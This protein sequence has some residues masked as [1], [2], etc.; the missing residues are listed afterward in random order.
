MALWPP[1][2]VRSLYARERIIASGNAEG[3]SYAERPDRMAIA[4]HAGLII[5]PLVVT[6]RDTPKSTLAGLDLAPLLL[7]QDA[8]DCDAERRVAGRT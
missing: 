6:F 2:R 3:A 5:R 1:I 7:L 4:N 8:G